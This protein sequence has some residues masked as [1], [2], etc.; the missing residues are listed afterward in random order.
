MEAKKGNYND[1]DEPE[2]L[3]MKDTTNQM[4]NT[5]EI[6]INTQD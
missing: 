4:K 2:I 3:E 5:T 6:I 1:K